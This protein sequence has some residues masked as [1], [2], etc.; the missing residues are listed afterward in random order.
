MVLPSLEESN[1]KHWSVSWLSVSSCN[2]EINRTRA[3]TGRI[4]QKLVCVGYPEAECWVGWSELRDTQHNQITLSWLGV[5]EETFLSLPC[6]L[7]VLCS[8]MQSLKWLE[9]MALESICL[10]LSS[11]LSFRTKAMMPGCRSEDRLST[12]LCNYTAKG[13]APQKCR[14]LPLVTS[15]WTV[16]PRSGFL[17]GRFVEGS[18]SSWT[19]QSYSFTPHGLRKPTTLGSL[20]AS[21]N[22]FTCLFFYVFIHK[23]ARGASVGFWILG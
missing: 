12:S 14:W 17:V 19:E 23:H 9:L 13:A 4:A 1:A 15:A 16:L 8:W 21:S 10:A 3:L 7:L 20:V 18:L 2:C 6:S 5:K 22:S 11:G